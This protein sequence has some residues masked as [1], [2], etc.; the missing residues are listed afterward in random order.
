MHCHCEIKE[1][2]YDVE[3]L[4]FKDDIS[5]MLEHAR[6]DLRCKTTSAALKQHP[7]GD[8][9]GSGFFGTLTLQNSGVV[10]EV[11]TYTN[12]YL[13][14]EIDGAE[15][16]GVRSVQIVIIQ[17][18]THQPVDDQREDGE[19]VLSGDTVEGLLLV[20]RHERD[21]AFERVGLFTVKGSLA[22]GKVLVEHETAEDVVIT[23]V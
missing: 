2:C 23:L 13:E 6:V 14:T 22:V 16:D 19:D 9:V 20:P 21:T 12:G 18:C 3:H 11:T 1:M 17:R 8:R 7:Q 10:I 15:S 4:D 5:G